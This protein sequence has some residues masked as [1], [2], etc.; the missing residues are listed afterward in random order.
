MAQAIAFVCGFVTRCRG[1]VIVVGVAA[2]V[3]LSCC[4]NMPKSP[5]VMPCVLCGLEVNIRING[6]SSHIN[7]VSFFHNKKREGQDGLDAA[8]ELR[9]SN[10][11]AYEE[12][13]A[14]QKEKKKRA[15]TV[16]SSESHGAGDGDG[17]NCGNGN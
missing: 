8:R 10:K 2:T 15:T 9:E 3:R 11:R 1:A 4:A 16:R 17:G 13:L 14:E 12:A 7:C 5:F 6:G